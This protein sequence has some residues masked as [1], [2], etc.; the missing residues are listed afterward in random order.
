L[1]NL[2]RQSTRALIERAVLLGRRREGLSR[3][4]AFL[5]VVQRQ[6]CRRDLLHDLDDGSWRS[7][8][9]LASI[10]AEVEMLSGSYRE[11]RRTKAVSYLQVF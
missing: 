4:L 5:D 11:V 7:T 10:N 3:P 9:A 2:L 1:L 8:N 6:G